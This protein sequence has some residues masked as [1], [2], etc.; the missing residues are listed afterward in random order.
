MREMTTLQRVG[1]FGL[2]GTSIALLLGQVLHVYYGSQAD[3]P[4]DGWMLTLPWLIV[5]VILAV[6]IAVGPRLRLALISAAIV[7]LLKLALPFLVTYMPGKD[8][9]HPIWL[10]GGFPDGEWID[11]IASATA[12]PVWAGDL[13][14]WFGAWAVL[15]F[16]IVTFLGLR[17]LLLARASTASFSIDMTVLLVVFFFISISSVGSVIYGSLFGSFAEL[18]TSS[19][20]FLQLL[21]LTW[22]LPVTLWLAF[23]GRQG[24]AVALGS[25][26]GLV[27]VL[28]VIPAL[29][30]Q[31]VDLLFD[32][33]SGGLVFADGG[34]SDVVPAYELIDR[35]GILPAAGVVA[36]VM[37]IIALWW[38]LGTH[39]G[40]NPVR[41]L[42]TTQSP[43][44]SLSVVAFV[45]AWIP[46]TAIPAVVLAHMSYDQVVDGDTAQR[47]IGLSR[48]AIVLGYL[49]LLGAFALSYNIWLS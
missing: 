13:L 37:F 16:T 40:G 28:L 4:R 34:I 12:F 43:V 24:G 49:S 27:A 30:N 45:L 5:V 10:G 41:A 3:G 29:L 20:L 8:K 48:W 2:L 44:N 23:T 42:G 33:S 1:L 9:A 21:L 26:A 35:V 46:L 39:S 25:T 36:V 22:L 47:G 38:G 14:L 15:A 18:A 19:S 6:A 11:S 7:I 31:L 17:S 32:G